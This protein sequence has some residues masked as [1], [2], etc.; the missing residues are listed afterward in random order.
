MN[1]KNP[2]SIPVLDLKRQYESIRE[3]MDAAVLEV[4]RSSKYVL[5][6]YVEEFEEKAGAYC[7]VEHAIGVASGTDALLLS[8]R[9]LGIGPG[10][11]VVLPSFTFVATAGVVHNV[12][13]TPVFCDIDPKTF[14]LDPSHLRSILADQDAA[15]GSWSVASGSNES[16]DSGARVPSTG[17]MPQATGSALRF[18]AVIPVHLYG[19]MADM[20][21]VLAIAKEYDLA[22]VE[23]AAQ[24]IGAEYWKMKQPV[25]GSQWDVDDSQTGGGEH[26]VFPQATSHPLRAASDPQATSHRRPAMK[27]GSLGALGCFSFYPTKNLGAYGDGGMVT[28][29]DEGL[30]ESVQL[31]RVHGAQPKYFHRLVGVNS[32]L[33]AIQA[34]VLTVKLAHLDSWSAAR[35]EKADLY[36]EALADVDGIVTPYRAVGRTHIFHQY[37][38]RVLGGRR[39]ALRDHLS[40]SGIGTMIY[41]PKPLHLQECFAHLG[42]R[43]GQ[44]P[45]SEAASCEVLSLPI[46]PE[47]T[48]EEQRYVVDAI[49]GFP[50]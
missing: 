28:S 45:Q 3:E 4:V 35:A 37:T 36:D 33:D 8:L 27:A 32:R 9:A 1:S 39:D 23:D 43:E 11:A 19:Q 20:D 7:G 21:E 17:H 46:F 6:P 47:L 14:N 25:A 30:A 5:G 29:N 40:A 12:G 41:Y 24:A 42:Y 10:D 38:I 34:A 2:M 16:G 48:E 31:L 13:A 22:V 49:K 26:G 15:R 50:W 18:K 44:L